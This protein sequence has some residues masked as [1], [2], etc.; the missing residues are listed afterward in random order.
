MSARQLIVDLLARDKTGA[1][2]KSAADNFED[3]GDAAKEAAKST[4]KLGDQANE[5]EDE[6]EKLGKSARTAAQHVD[7][8]DHEIESV[9][10]ELRQLAVAF[11]EAETAAD[12]L[13]LS[14]AI[15]RTQSD[16]R[17]LNQ[18]KGLLKD[19]VPDVPDDVGKGFVKTLISDIGEGLSAVR[20]PLATGVVA[21]LAPTVAG[22]LAAAVI[23][24]VGLG[25]IIGGIAL[26]A[27]DPS[28]ADRAKD[29]GASF[30]AGI[31]AE[32]RDAFGGPIQES[33]GQLEQF[34]ARSVPKIGAIFDATAPSLRGFTADVTH[35]GDALLDGLVDA[36]RS[37]APVMDK[38]GDLVADTGDSV[39]DF[40]S[41]VADHSDEAASSLDDLNQTLQ[42][43]LAGT[44]VAVGALLTVRGAIDKV[45][46]VAHTTDIGGDIFD[47]FKASLFGPLG[48]L[49]NLAEKFKSTEKAAEPA[50]AAVGAMNENLTLMAMKAAGVSGPIVTLSDQINDMADASRNAFDAATDVGA[51]I[52]EVTEAA[53]KNGATLDVNTEKGRANRQALSSLA[54]SMIAAYNA[55]VALTGEGEKANAVAAQNREKFIQLATALTGS[56]KRAEE[57]ATQLGLIKGPPPINIKDNFLQAKARAASIQAQLDKLPRTVPVRV[58]VTRT[59][60]ITYGSGGGRQAPM[61]AQG[62]PVTAGMPYV[63]GEKR[64]ELFV[65]E[66]NGYVYPSVGAAARS[67]G[68]G[69][70][71][72]TVTVAA[73]GALDEFERLILKMLRTRPAFAATVRQ[74]VG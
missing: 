33:L 10:H 22:G 24:G 55:E 40:L 27:K 30:K 46:E 20:G 11:A 62:G 38:L 67:A 29:I 12:R 39:G 58:I 63:V 8:L 16:L 32:A 48:M 64:P 65:P 14:K 9:E 25:G 3:V 21:A 28:V 7:R 36:A 44:T 43:L 31:T 47:D 61:R 23:G 68:G 72:A 26:V 54:D 50:A 5:A 69:M 18:S 53:K 34:A 57:L 4:E 52:D 6:V 73:S 37:S 49:G 56:R 74:Y 1:A 70:G 71:G 51:A 59:G 66:S 60:E 15:R 35:A 19:L 45:G 17:K 41:T 2:T 13:D 42:G